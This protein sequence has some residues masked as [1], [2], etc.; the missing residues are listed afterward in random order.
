MSGVYILFLLSLQ[1][2]QLFRQQ[3]EHAGIIFG[4][5]QGAVLACQSKHILVN[6]TFECGDTK[7]RQAVVFHPLKTFHWIFIHERQ[8]QRREDQGFDLALRT[9][10]DIVAGKELV[11]YVV[12]SHRVV[13]VASTGLDQ[14]ATKIH[15]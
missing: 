10:S 2:R 4:V 15:I 8:T 12:V 3:R 9:G 5:A 7:K 1:W 14:P 13:G 6:S 11:E